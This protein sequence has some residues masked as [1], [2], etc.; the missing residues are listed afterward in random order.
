MAIEHKDIPDAELHEP[1]GAAGAAA[2]DMFI[3]DGAGSGSWQASIMSNHGQMTITNNAT[4]TSVT[5]A[6]DATLNTDTDYVK[7]TAGWGDAHVHGVTFNTDEL[8]CA[9]DGHYE[10][11]F[12]ASI[13]IP[14]NNN[15]VG[16]K[17]SIN[18]ST[19][20][21]PQKLVSQSATTDDYRNMMGNSGVDLTAG[22]TISIYV[23]AS[24][25]DSLVVEEAGLT[26]Q[27]T[28]EL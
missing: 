11:S 10:V 9:I 16:I 18:D 8:V 3:A 20:Y 28:H 27:L 23:A 12:W 5:G 6:V 26:L 22:D 21:S 25:T 4:A 7:I 17:F 15:F 19:P 1:K 14:Q 24:K 2:G 13:K